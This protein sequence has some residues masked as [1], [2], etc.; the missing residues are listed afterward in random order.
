MAVGLLGILDAFG[1]EPLNRF[2]VHCS[3]GCDDAAHHAD[4]HH[5]P[6]QQLFLP[7][8]DTI[9]LY[10]LQGLLVDSQRRVDFS[11]FNIHNILFQWS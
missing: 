1:T 4:L 11:L 3:I 2:V 8:T 10:L 9:F 7:G 6:E 5:Q